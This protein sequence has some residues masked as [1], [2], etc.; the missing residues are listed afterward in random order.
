MNRKKEYVLLFVLSIIFLAAGRYVFRIW[1]VYHEAE[2][3]YQ[4][5]KQYIVEGADEDEVEG[6]KDQIADSKAAE[7]IVRK[8]DFEGLRTINEDIVAWIQ[9]PGIGVDY[10]VVQGE[11]NEHYLH[12]TFDG[13]ENIA[14]SIFLDY[15]N[16]ADFTDRKVILYG[17]NMQDGSMFSHLA[18]YQDKDFREE[19][20]RV[21][22]YL[23]GKT[24]ECEVLECRQM[25]VRDTVYEIIEEEKR[26]VP[27]QV[28]LSTCSTSDDVRL[29][30]I[31][32]VK[33]TLWI[34]RRA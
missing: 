31:C 32:K 34:Y 12:Y 25:P 3:G 30:L 26:K 13:K 2:E 16:R 4:K 21:I 24:L 29:V 1:E 20:G 27:D 17:H 23:P 19:Q 18:K 14:G 9:I 22:L 33:I 5:L 7:E 28:M 6:E 11:D 8:I 10:P 15:R